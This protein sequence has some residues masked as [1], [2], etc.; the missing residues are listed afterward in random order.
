MDFEKQESVKSK[1]D[2]TE[3]DSRPAIHIKEA[4][5]APDRP[6]GL[7]VDNGATSKDFRSADNVATSKELRS[8]EILSA[9]TSQAVE[10]PPQKKTGDG[11]SFACGDYQLVSVLGQGGMGT[12]YKARHPEMST[13]FAIK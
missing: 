4:E 3:V 9:A 5:T 2:A 1:Q 13:E 10:D 8:A 7:S 12:V 6:E 11:L